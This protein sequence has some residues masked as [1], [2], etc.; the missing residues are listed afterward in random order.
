MTKLAP[1]DEAELVEAVAAANA[2]G[3]RLEL[4][5]RGSKR[6]IGRPLQVEA[7]LDL[8]R[9]SGIVAYEPDELV[10]TAGPATP[11]AEIEALLAGQGQALAFEPPDFGP[12]LGEPAAAGSLGGAVAAN[13]GGP[14]RFKAGAARD[15]LLGFKAV[16][17]EGA[18]FKSGGRVVKN[19]TGYDLSKLMAGSWGT[20]AAMTELT[21]KVLPA[22]Q[23]TRTLLLI[24]QD[25]A[26]AG[27]A[28]TAAFLSAAEVSG[29]A[30][31]PAG[32]ARAT[33]L[34]LVA[35]T[36]SAVTALR[37]EGPAP[38]VAARLAGLR[39]ILPSGPKQAVL[40]DEDS[41]SLWRSIAD[42]RGFV[43]DSRPLWRISLTPT[44][45]PV[46]LRELGV[47]EDDAFL[48]WGGGLLWATSAEPEALVG[49]LAAVLSSHGGEATLVRGPAA[50]R[51]T[52]ASLPE[53]PAALIALA[54]RVKS[55]FDPKGLFNPG[56]IYAGI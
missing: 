27:L 18:R 33:Q 38:S 56:R 13:L 26:E 54:R 6:A 9:F 19:V 10:L 28:M 17:G 37:M 8:S 2:R 1:A 32:Q 36:G 46:V 25:A 14:R 23:A 15:H 45:G 11:L 53:Q 21:V 42:A 49:R 29:A 16:S 7:T 44:A 5:G 43:G 51:A 47:S 3:T 41:R 22:G 30:W 20:L 31:L 48:D 35:S 55:S 39:Q 40:D 50:L 4:V 12:L 24:G 52:G 34:D